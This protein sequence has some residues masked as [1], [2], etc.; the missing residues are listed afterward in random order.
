M[1]CKGERKSFSQKINWKFKTMIAETEHLATL[2]NN[3]LGTSLVPDIGNEP[4]FNTA[5]QGRG[6]GNCSHNS[7][8]LR[9]CVGESKSNLLLY[10]HGICKKWNHRPAS[11]IPLFSRFQGD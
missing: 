2:A 11:Y 1:S 3:V 9:L 6:D 5:V 7:T 10:C 8:S 4:G